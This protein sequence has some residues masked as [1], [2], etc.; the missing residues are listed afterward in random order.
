[1]T[2]N[3]PP[4]KLTLEDTGALGSEPCSTLRITSDSTVTKADDTIKK[5]LAAG[6]RLKPST[7]FGRNARA[8]VLQIADVKK[9]LPLSYLIAMGQISRALCDLDR[10]AKPSDEKVTVWITEQSATTTPARRIN[11][12]LTP[13]EKPRD[14]LVYRAA[15]LVR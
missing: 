11:E 3:Q 7:K 2:V 10:K 13:A 6:A 8:L 9:L 14:Q 12:Y 4:I 15:G 5:I 1:M